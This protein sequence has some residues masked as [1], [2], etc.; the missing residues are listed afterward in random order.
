M[1]IDVSTPND[2]FLLNIFNDRVA[3][4]GATYRPAESA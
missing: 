4:I 2:T 1:T 3:R